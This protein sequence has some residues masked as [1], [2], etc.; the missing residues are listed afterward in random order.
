SPDEGRA[1]AMDLVKR[2]APR[3]IIDAQAIATEA[4]GH[5]LF[6]GELVRYSVAHGQSQTSRGVIRLE[7][8]LSSRIAA[9]D[10]TSPEILGLLGTAGAPVRLELL[11]R[12]AAVADFTALTKQ[13]QT[14]RLANLVKAIAS[15]GDSYV[16]EVYHDR[17][18]QTLLGHLPPTERARRHERLA[19]ALE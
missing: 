15:H 12:A 5:P 13:V 2:W 16:L 8:A 19:Q 7:D 4:S 1:L 10:D 6:I 17:V 11:A 18:R 3:G 9:L 14:L